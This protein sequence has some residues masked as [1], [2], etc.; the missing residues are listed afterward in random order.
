MTRPTVQTIRRKLTP[1]PQHPKHYF[2]GLLATSAGLFIA[3]IWTENQKLGMT[4]AVTIFL[5]VV[6]GFTW[7]IMA[8]TGKLRERERRM[9]GYRDEDHRDHY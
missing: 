4:G 9:R 2:F 8:D 1:G 7:L 3:A 6:S 5:T